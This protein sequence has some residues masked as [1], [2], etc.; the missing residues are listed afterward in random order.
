MFSTMCC[1]CAINATYQNAWLGGRLDI[2]VCAR[3]TSLRGGNEV[4]VAPDK[5]MSAAVARFSGLAS[6]SSKSGNVSMLIGRRD[7]SARMYVVMDSSIAL[8]KSESSVKSPDESE[9]WLMCVCV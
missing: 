4:I 7:C 9:E 2:V 6:D 8:S 5:D 3:A 1:V